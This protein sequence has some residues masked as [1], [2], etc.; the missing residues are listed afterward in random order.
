MPNCRHGREVESLH[1]HSNGVRVSRRKQLAARPK[2]TCEFGDRAFDTIQL[3]EHV[4]RHRKLMRRVR[5][6]EPV[7]VGHH[8]LGS[9]ASIGQRFATG[10]HHARP[11]VATC[12]PSEV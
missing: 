4:V 2:Y 9:Q 3:I 11:D 8:E 10:I 5:E 6:W 7:Y 12:E 1:W